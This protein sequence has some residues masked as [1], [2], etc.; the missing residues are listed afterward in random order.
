MSDAEKAVIEAAEAEKA[1][2]EAET[3][4]AASEAAATAVAAAQ[5]GA[6]LANANA[7]KAQAEA[8]EDIEENEEELSWLKNQVETQGKAI[9]QLSEGQSHLTN[10]TAS[11]LAGVEKL[12]ASISKASEQPSQ[13]EV[14]TEAANKKEQ[15]SSP[16]PKE[17]PTPKTPRQKAADPDRPKRHWI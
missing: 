12:T 7:A 4:R 17:A 14:N 13:P 15:A 10:Q 5:A 16:E 6:G 1:K 9:N 3:A 11:I 8:A 2:A